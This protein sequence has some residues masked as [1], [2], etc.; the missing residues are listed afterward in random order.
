MGDR[1]Y[2]DQR[3]KNGKPSSLNLVTPK[4]IES[5]E[6]FI[7]LSEANSKT[8]TMEWLHNTFKT[9]SGIIRYLH[10]EVG[11]DVKTI[12]SYTS[13]PYRHIYSVVN[14]KGDINPNVCPVC[15]N[16]KG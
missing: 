16:R 2:K 4:P 13:W 8:P 9:K 14:K 12:A 10:K 11:M 15:M 7:A 6:E 3:K 5:L 1:F